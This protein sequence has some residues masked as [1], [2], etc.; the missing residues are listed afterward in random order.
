MFFRLPHE[1]TLTNQLSKVMLKVCRF[2]SCKL[3]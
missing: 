3:E 2:P 1:N